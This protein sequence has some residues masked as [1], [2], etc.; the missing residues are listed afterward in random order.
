ML[1]CP[2]CAWL[3]RPGDTIT[4]A[5]IKTLM[6]PGILPLFLFNV[7]LIVQ[8]LHTTNQMVN[9]VGY[10]IGAVNCAVL[11][12]GLVLNAAPAGYLLDVWLVLATVAICFRDLGNAT[13]SSPFRMWPYVV[14][15]LDIALVFNRPNSLYRFT[16]TVVLVYQV[17]LQVESV[18]RFGLYEAGY[19]GGAGVEDSFCNC[20]SPPCNVP[21]VD[22]VVNMLSVCIVLLGDFYFTNGFARGMELQLRKVE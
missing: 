18:A 14:I 7:F 5:R 10:S 11:M 2:S 9:I 20:A 22:A 6:M 15:L 4:E 1:G 16:I 3:V 19:W 21:A 12:G 17:F 8:T 13:A